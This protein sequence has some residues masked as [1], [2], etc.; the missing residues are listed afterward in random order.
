M[1]INAKYHL[2][3]TEN[4]DPENPY[5]EVQVCPELETLVAGG[6][7]IFGNNLLCLKTYLFNQ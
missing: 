7:E 3:Q 6:I 2:A 1:R 5:F 4:L